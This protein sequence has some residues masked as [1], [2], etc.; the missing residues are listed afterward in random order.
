MSEH[1]RPC[2]A[3]GHLAAILRGRHSCRWFKADEVPRREIEEMLALAQT[4][5]SWCN[6]QPW[7]VSILSGNARERLSEALL[8]AARSE[9]KTPDFNPPAEYPSIHNARRRQ[10]GYALY[11]SVGIPRHD[12]EARAAQAREN[13]RFFNAPHVALITTDERLG[14]Y[15]AVDCGG[16]VSTLLL[17]AESLGIAAVP[18]AAIAMYAGVVRKELCL[19][20]GKRIVCAVSFG[21]EDTAHPANGF[22]TPRS[23]L[24][25]VVHWFDT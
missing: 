18:Q 22:R 8:R 13:Y 14:V 17:A 3:P 7:Q 15:G 20:E 10:A 16:Y 12:A 24:D 9:P 2:G 11:A 5:P 1:G 25:E 19:P 21:Y 23:G 4:T 6:V